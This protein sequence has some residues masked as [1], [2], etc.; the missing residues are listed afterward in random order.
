MARFQADAASTEIKEEIIRDVQD[1]DQ[2]GVQGTPTIFVNGQR[3]NGSLDLESF[4][5][6]L[7]AAL[8]QGT[9]KAQTALLRR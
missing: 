6:V 7:D 1:G 2:A 3:Y 8:K 5:P 4:K 9:P